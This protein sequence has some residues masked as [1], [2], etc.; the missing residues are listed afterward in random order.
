MSS[1]KRCGWLARGVKL[2]LLASLCFSLAVGLYGC[3]FKLRGDQRFAFNTLYSG[4]AATSEMGAQFR[5][6]V[7]L[8]ESTTITS[9]EATAQA[10]LVILGE[11]R[12]PKETLSISTTGRP[13]EYLLRS[14]L[15]FKLLG[16]VSEGPEKELIPTSEIILRRTVTASDQDFGAKQ[17]EEEL[18]YR[19]MLNDLV[20]Q[21]MRRLAAAKRSP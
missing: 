13:R 14:R 11:G 3:G 17:L 9:E 8:A 19:E 21:L 10:R 2:G 16:T 1:E 6:N 4:F 12:L 7:R 18:L 15:S 20:D 5:R